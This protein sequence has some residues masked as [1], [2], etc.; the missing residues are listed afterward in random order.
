MGIRI[1]RKAGL[2]V[3]QN[4]QKKDHVS[5]SDEDRYILTLEKE[6]AYLTQCIATTLKKG[7]LCF[8]FF[9]SYIFTYFSFVL[10]LA[11]VNTCS[12]SPFQSRL[13]F[14]LINL[15]AVLW[16]FNF[17]ACFATQKKNIP[18]LSLKFLFN[19]SYIFIYALQIEWICFL[20]FLDL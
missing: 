6:L 15:D 20:L 8:F 18:T 7:M 19:V 5:N 10:W 3:I 12:I 13:F 17:Q 4:T 11:F 2:K 9:A 14:K 16:L 1:Y